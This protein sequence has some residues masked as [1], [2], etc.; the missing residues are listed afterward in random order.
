[1]KKW[2]LMLTLALAVALAVAPLAAAKGGALKNGK[3][4]AKF[5]LVG[6]VTAV[7][8]GGALTVKVKA[9]TKTVKKYRGYELSLMAGQAAFRLVTPEGCLV[10]SLAD[11]EGQVG[12]KVKVRGVIDRSDPENVLFLASW[13]KVKALPIVVDPAPDPEAVTPE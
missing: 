4:K 3:G 6:T 12:A 5:N 9:G 8:P 1:M 2:I 10:A 7:D 11:L 13:V